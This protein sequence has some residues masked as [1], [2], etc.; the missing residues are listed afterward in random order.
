MQGLKALVIV[1]GVMIVAGVVVIG[2][3][4]YNRLSGM[5]GADA[6]GGQAFGEVVLP[7]PPDSRVV[8]THVTEGRLIAVIDSR[9]G[10]RIAVVDLRTGEPLGTVKLVPAP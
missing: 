8:S 5:A 4:I 1:M 10:Q 2:V 3:T 7:V 6:G 9:D